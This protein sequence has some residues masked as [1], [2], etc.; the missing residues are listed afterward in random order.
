LVSVNPYKHM[1]I[2]TT[3]Y[4]KEYI[5]KRLGSRPPHIYATANAAY[6]ALTASKR[7]QAVII[8]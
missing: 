6:T 7:N 4:V 3:Q 8:R 1:P 5:G 2:Y